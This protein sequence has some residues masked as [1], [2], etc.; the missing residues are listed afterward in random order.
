VKLYPTV[1]G[2]RYLMGHG[3]TLALVAM[4]CII[5]GSMSTYFAVKNKR[6]REG[7]E[8]HKVQGMTEEQ[9]AELGDESPRYMYTK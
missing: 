8:D 6:R 3:T 4:S 7:K 1:D 9:I 5:F 2:P